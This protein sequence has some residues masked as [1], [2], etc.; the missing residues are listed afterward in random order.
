MSKITCTING[1][2]KKIDKRSENLKFGVLM[3]STTDAGYMT[4][5]G[6]LT[7]IIELSYP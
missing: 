4:Y 2:L 5:Y 7:N 6:I 1:I 3:Y